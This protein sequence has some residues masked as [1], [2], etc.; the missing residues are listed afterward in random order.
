M[1]SRAS[2]API[3]AMCPA[4]PAD[5][6]WPSEGYQ[7]MKGLN[8]LMA[9]LFHGLHD[10]TARFN[11][12]PPGTQLPLDAQEKP[13]HRLTLYPTNRARY[14]H[15]LR[16]ASLCAWL[17]RIGRGTKKRSG[18]DKSFRFSFSGC[19]SVALSVG[20][21]EIFPQC[22]KCLLTTV[23]PYATIIRLVAHG[24]M[25]ERLMALVLKT[26]DAE[27]HRG[28]ESLSLRQLP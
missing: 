15:T 22:G 17:R 12:T 9:R 24:E 20:E 5:N 10:E 14:E 6:H 16:E 3:S 28:F 21:K 4:P 1:P 8:R 7:G 18:F 25:A 23:H 2:R 19:G 26:S 27:R 13:N 11:R